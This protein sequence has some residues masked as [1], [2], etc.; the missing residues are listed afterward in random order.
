MSSGM[1]LSVVNCSMVLQ[2]CRCHATKL[3]KSYFTRRL[4][5]SMPSEAQACLTWGESGLI[6]DQPAGMGDL[7]FNG[8]ASE[9]LLLLELAILC[10]SM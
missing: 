6:E 10:L 1:L 4:S 8:T 5:G 9:T 7:D 2:W 3:K